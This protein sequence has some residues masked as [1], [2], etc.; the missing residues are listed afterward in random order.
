MRFAGIAQQ[1]TSEEDYVLLHYA[2]YRQW[3]RAES[4]RFMRYQ[5][6]LQLGF[7]L[8]TVNNIM[9]G[10]GWYVH[11]PSMLILMSIAP[12]TRILA[13]RIPDITSHL[14]DLFG[15]AT[16][17]SGVRIYYEAHFLNSF[18]S[19]NAPILVT[20]WLVCSGSLRSSTRST[21][22]RNM[23]LIV[24][25]A[26]L[27]YYWMHR[28]MLGVLVQFI[29]GLMAGTFLAHYIIKSRWLRFYH[30]ALNQEQRYFAYKELAKIVPP[31]VVRHIEGGHTLESSMPTG[32]ASACVISFDIIGSSKVKHPLFARAVEELA[33]ACYQIMLENY[34]EKALVANAYRIK[35]TGD[36]FLCS[37][38]FPYRTPG[39]RSA[40]ELAIEV[41]QRF[42]EKFR[43]I[44][45][46]LS[47]HEPLRCAI[48]IS[49][50]LVEGFFPVSG[51]KQYDLRGRPLMLATR[52]EA[53]RNALVKENGVDFRQTSF[54][55][56]QEA[57]YQNLP[58]HL[59]QDFNEWDT[60]RPGYSI[61]DDDQAKVAYYQLIPCA[62]AYVKLKKQA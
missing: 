18:G 20:T 2:A 8:F 51:V 29:E 45:S 60:T 7:M 32:W 19:E 23:L 22:L 31:H 4:L 9:K 33:I 53:L 48:G 15:L 16:I 52:Y 10:V 59:Q 34:D 35:D 14:W 43:L 17:F 58:R 49:Q 12:L 27:A 6:I 39:T 26:G 41:S 1:K 44:M 50:G 25:G 61:R 40:A 57:V 42:A 37:V 11:V 54:L 47:Y 3:N 36:G 21:V 55:I 13:P 24:C 28:E 56:I 5:W 30:M 46:E 38:G 62:Q